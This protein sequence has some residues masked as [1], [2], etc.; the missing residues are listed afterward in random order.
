[1]AIN[2]PQHSPLYRSPHHIFRS[3]SMATHRTPT[4]TPSLICSVSA[5]ETYHR[6]III[7]HSIFMIC[8]RWTDSCVDEWIDIYTNFSMA[9]GQCQWKWSAISTSVLSLW[10]HISRCCI[11]FY[12][13]IALPFLCLS[14]CPWFSLTLHQLYGNFECIYTYIYSW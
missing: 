7:A 13:F 6:F 4:R 10:C 8:C 11:T 14:P 2:T 12:K 3:V 5:W 9:R 1:M